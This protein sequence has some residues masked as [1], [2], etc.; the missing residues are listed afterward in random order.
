MG[1][2]LS[3][4]YISN[5]EKSVFSLFSQI[6]KGNMSKGP[7]QYL[8]LTYLYGLHVDP[9]LSIFVKGLSYNPSLREVSQHFYLFHT[10]NTPLV[11][12]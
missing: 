1:F 8:H 10:L 5:K 4:L 12:G 11:C 7:L 9:C 3:L 2:S 6:I